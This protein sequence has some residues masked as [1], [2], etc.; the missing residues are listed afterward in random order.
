M[1]P[2]DVMLHS[3]HVIPYY[4]PIVS[5]DT[6]QIIGYE[7]KAYYSDG[8]EEKQ[9]LD[10]FFNDPTIPH[11]FQLDVHSWIISKA[12]DYYIET[13][14]S[15][16]LF[17]NYHVGTLYEDHGETL[18]SQFET[19]Q[20]KGLDLSKIVIELKE[21][22]IKEEMD[23]LFPLLKYMKTLG[24]QIAIDDVG[25]TNGNLAQLIHYEPNIIKIDLR[26]LKD[27]AIP[28]LYRDIHYSITMLA[29]KIGAT[30]LFKKISNYSQFS[31]AWR[32]GGRYYQGLYFG[33]SQDHFVDP[34]TYKETMERDFQHF[35][36]YEKKKM[37]AQV[38]LA[39][40]L[41]RVFTEQLDD[42]D[43]SAPLDEIIYQ[44]AKTCDSFAFRV[45]ICN[46]EGIQLSADAKKDQDG[47]WQLLE[48]EKHKNW[49]WRPYFFE[50]I[51]RMN[52]EKKGILSDLYTDI[53][54]N[55]QIRT[56]SYPIAKQKYIFID[57][58]FSYLYEQEGLL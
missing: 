28:H 36:E 4:K 54:R 2:L 19:Y 8:K 16:L 45:Y 5:A 18:L 44:V 1:D 58:P 29:H 49:S 21:N 13:D 42:L 56:F 7:V 22:E 35:V 48:D 37:K 46:D 12:L 11:D 15:T 38:H 30:L 51:I 10:W 52:V 26:A 25:Q 40:Q 43:Y 31:Y 47:D 57:I 6:G 9:R 55:E 41:N 3:D 53:V 33:K 34:N 17:F 39:N 23:S 20:E 14:Q 50:N 27:V 24:I 32:N